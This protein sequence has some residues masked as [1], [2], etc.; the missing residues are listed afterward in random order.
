MH[1]S[2]Y[3]YIWFIIWD[4][5]IGNFHLS[6]R[7]LSNKFLFV[8][9]GFVIFIISY[10]WAMH[11]KCVF[12]WNGFVTTSHV[13]RSMIDDPTTWKTNQIYFQCENM[14]IANVNCHV[15]S[16]N[17]PFRIEWWRWCNLYYTLIFM[18]RRIYERSFSLQIIC[19][20]T[21]FK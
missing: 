14:G 20:R 3:W 2:Y 12:F 1:A 19:Q 13:V 9:T 15:Q 18:R 5:L 7:S 6:V 17:L 11:E 4:Y 10:G 21:S 8:S 16:C